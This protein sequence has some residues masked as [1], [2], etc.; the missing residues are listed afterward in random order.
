M[1]IFPAIDLLDGRCVRLY[2]GNYNAET[3]YSEDPLEQVKIFEAQGADYL[4]VVDLNAARSGGQENLAIIEN[5]CAR[6]KLKVQT[7]GG[8]RNMTALDDRFAVGVWRC[9]IGTAAITDPGFTQEAL[10]IYGQK[11]AVGADCQGDKIAV[12]GWTT[13]TEVDLASFVRDLYQMGC[14][15]LIYTDISRDGALSGPNFEVA[16]S[17]HETSGMQIILSGGIAHESDI[18]TAEHMGFAAVITGKALYENRVDLEKC[19]RYI[20]RLEQAHVR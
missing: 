1:I 3:V 16:K 18:V 4:H 20:K 14:R 6:T 9:V 8:L 12:H 17:L 19:L 7:G 5:I 2:Q 10:R 11:I 13:V 15:H